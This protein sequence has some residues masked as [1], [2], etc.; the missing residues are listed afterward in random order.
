MTSGAPPGPRY[1][2]YALAVL[3]VA[4]VLAFVDRQVLNLLVEPIKHDTGLSDTQ[5]SL[6]QGLSF[7]LF[8][9]I[10]GLPIGR[11][12]DTSHRTR[13]LAIGIGIWSLM[14]GAFGLTHVFGVML[15][16]R[17]GV[18]VGEATMTPSAYSLLGDYFP[19]HRLGLA[20]GLFSMGGYFG[21][22]LALILG[23]AALTL[24]PAHDMRAPLIG[25]VHPWQAIFLSL[26]PIGLVIAVWV[27]TLREPTRRNGDATSAPDWRAM[28]AYFKAMWRPLLGVNLSVGFTV[29]AAYGLLAWAPALITR[30]YGLPPAQAGWRLGILLIVAC[31]SGT[32]LA[33]V[34][35]DRLRAQGLATGRLIV[36]SAALAAAL[37]F[38]AM[39]P[40]AES[41]GWLLAGLA[42]LLF[43][44]SMATGCGPTLLQEITPNRLRGVQHSLAVLAANLLGLGLGPTVVALATEHLFG[45]PSSVG[46][47]LSWILPLCLVSALG[48][49][50]LSRRSYERALPSP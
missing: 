11:L 32:L 1:A 16:S 6:L 31:C 30:R 10:G 21:S 22:G 20:V 33:G 17:I 37:P 46:I 48:V 36:M 27:A 39:T 50:I 42:P 44:L 24:L 26:V 5:I 15:L 19:P 40:R 45:G 7:A 35:G 38:A 3:F 43:F 28:V 8:L 49:S 18:S 12:I 13:L 25:P 9:S 2:P 29:M 47:S 4:Y 14:T 41:F 34:I 23:S